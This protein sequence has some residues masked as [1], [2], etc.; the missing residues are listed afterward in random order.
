MGSL[1][2][3]VG[4]IAKE[5]EANEDAC[6]TDADTDECS[7]TAAD[8]CRGRRLNLASV[9]VRLFIAV[10]LA[11]C[12]AHALRSI[13]FDDSRTGEAIIAKNSVLKSL[14]LQA[15]PIKEAC[16]CIESVPTFHRAPCARDIT[17]PP[18]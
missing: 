5:N 4:E 18:P 14:Q 3:Q 2:N 9:F 16:E 12:F 11:V 7:E 1:R 8:T 15:C 6:G 10:T 17:P 13:M